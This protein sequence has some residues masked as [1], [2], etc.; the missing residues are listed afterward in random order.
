M[1]SYFQ[2]ERETLA[3]IR[4]I[5]HPHL[6]MPVASFAYHSEDNGCFLF[7]WAEGGNLREFWVREQTLPLKNSKMMQWV[8]TQM[9]GL[10]HGLSILH[11]K[12][13]RHGDLKPENILLFHKGG[14]KGTLQIADV[15]LAKHHEMQTQQRKDLMQR[16]NTMTGTTRYVSPEFVHADVIPRVFDTWALGCVFVEF[17]IWMLYGQN[18]LRDFTKQRFDH[19]WEK[20]GVEFVVHTDV[21]SWLDRISTDLVGP[22][23]ALASLFN[24][25]QSNMLVPDDAKRSDSS[26]VYQQLA[27]ICDRA[28]KE[29]KYLLDDW[30][31]SKISTRAPPVVKP[32]GANLTVPGSL[33]KPR[34]PLRQGQASNAEVEQH[35][36]IPIHIQEPEDAAPTRVA[37]FPTTSKIAQDVSHVRVSV[38]STN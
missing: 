36:D 14:Y 8:L 18:Q 13:R 9:R 3:V 11:S 16:T 24:L 28:A 1:G 35:Q 38:I 2:K 12:E 37:T 10:C 21:K 29:P 15:G 7:P 33:E 31:W 30:I 32:S 26:D 4:E 19:F 6:I 20:K 5:D 25:V 34:A 22:E 17:I 27:L 23:S